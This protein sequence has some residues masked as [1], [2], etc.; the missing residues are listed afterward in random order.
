MLLQLVNGL[1]LDTDEG[2]GKLRKA[3]VR[4]KQPE[5]LGYPNE[6]L[7]LRAIPKGRGTCT[8]EASY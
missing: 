3:Q 8:S 2:R 1:A 6:I 7:S 4:R 5:T